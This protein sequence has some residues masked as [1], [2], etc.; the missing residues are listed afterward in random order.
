MKK[1]ICGDSIFFP[2]YVKQNNKIYK[3]FKFSE[4]CSY[5]TYWNKDMIISYKT[6]Q[7]DW[8][9]LWLFDNSTHIE[10]I[11]WLS[12]STLQTKRAI[13]GLKKK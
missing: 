8:P 11:F 12:C 2:I 3:P 1:L 4:S 9:A 7:V 10:E 13:Y 5:T 6:F